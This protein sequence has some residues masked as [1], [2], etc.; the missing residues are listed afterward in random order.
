MVWDLGVQASTPCKILSAHNGIVLALK[1]RDGKLV[2]SL[3]GGTVQIWD[4]NTGVCL[5]TLHGHS[6]WVV[7]ARFDQYG[8]LATSDFN[9]LGKVWSVEDG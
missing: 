4:L 8:N 3:E 7:H 5:H 6:D 2:S 1:I 9:S